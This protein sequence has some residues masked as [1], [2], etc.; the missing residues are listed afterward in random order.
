MIR[1][2]VI[3]RRCSLALAP[4]HGAAHAAPPRP[5]SRR[6]R[7]SPA[8]SCASAI[9][10]RTPAPSPTCRSSARPTS[11]RPARCRPTRGR[12]GARARL[13]GLDTGGVTEVMVTRA[14]R[15]IPAEDIEDAHRA[16]ARRAIRARRRQGPHRDFRP[17][18]A[19]DAV[20]SPAP[21]ATR[22]SPRSIY[23]ARSGRF[24]ADARTCRPAP[25]RRGTLRLHRP[26]ARRP[27]RSSCWRARVERGARDQGRRRRGRAP[28][29]RRDRPRHHHRPRP[30]GRPCRAQR[31]QAGR[32]LRSADL[33]KPET[34]AA[35]RD[36]D[37]GLRGARH[38]R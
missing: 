32:P 11:A 21:T 1:I 5:S 6:R 27:S 3:A 31:L 35:Q 29:A 30:G 38:H 2:L 14:S 17:R 28:S 10:S 7:P 23:D 22:A 25:A 16:R 34:R 12:G 20:S 9:W 33:M 19:R 24:E 18:A 37:A 36:G 26:C 8:T 13:I 4:P 15:T